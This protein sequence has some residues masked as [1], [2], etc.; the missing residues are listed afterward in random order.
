MLKAT[1][2]TFFIPISHLSPKLKEA[3][4]SAYLCMRAIDEIE[5]HPEL[6]L[7]SKSELLISISQVLRKPFNEDELM[8]LFYPYKTLLPEVTLRLSDWIKL[9]PPT[10]LENILNATSTMAKGMADWVI[11]EWRFKNEEDLDEY[12]YF[13]A[14][15]VG[16]MLTDIWKWYDGTETDEF[17]AIAFGRGLQSVNILRNYKEDMNRGVNF[18]PDGWELEDMF[19]YARRNLEL[20]NVYLNDIKSETILNFCKIPLVLAHGTLESLIIGKEK[21]SRAEVVEVVNQIVGKH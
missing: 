1:S 4:T 7:K 10:I 15:L 11:K 5:D 16:V 14:G 12:T 18:F 17:L 19:N 8:A 21:M 20:G 13:V 9:C 6:K 2:R 3:V